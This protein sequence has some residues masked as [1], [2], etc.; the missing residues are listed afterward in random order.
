MGMTVVNIY[1]QSLY[2]RKKFGDNTIRHVIKIRNN[3]SIGKSKLEII[4]KWA[5]IIRS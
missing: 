3:V 4:F 5:K 1:S 2:Y